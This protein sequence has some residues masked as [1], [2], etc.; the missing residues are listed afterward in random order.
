MVGGRGKIIR[1][2][3]IFN[4]IVGWDNARGVVFEADPRHVEIIIDQLGLK[5][6]K[7]VSTPGAK[8][9]GRTANDCEEPLGEQQSSQYQA[10]M[11]RF[12]N[13]VPD[14]P[15]VADTVKELA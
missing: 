10:I 11:A 2:K 13:I 8:D 4:H 14:R 6:A 7:A 15:N 9:N 3:Y 1:R 5:G 12:N